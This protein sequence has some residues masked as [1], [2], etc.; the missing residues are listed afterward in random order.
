MR[1]EIGQRS[2]AVEMKVDFGDGVSCCCSFWAPAFGFSDFISF[3]V[4]CVD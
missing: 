1:R 4:C 3:I 2:E